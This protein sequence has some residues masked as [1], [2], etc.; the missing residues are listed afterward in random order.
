VH[1]P[2]A[3]VEKITVSKKYEVQSL[4]TFHGISMLLKPKKNGDSFPNTGQVYFTITIKAPTN[5]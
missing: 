1:R 3:E 4:D 5:F 2:I